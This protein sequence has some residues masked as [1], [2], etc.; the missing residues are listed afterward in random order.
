MMAVFISREK[1]REIERLLESVPDARD[2]VVEAE[3]TLKAISEYAPK[4]DRDW[5]DREKSEL[6]SLVDTWAAVMPSR[7]TGQGAIRNQAAFNSLAAERLIDSGLGFD[8][9]RFLLDRATR[10]FEAMPSV[11]ALGQDV[12]S[13]LETVDRIRNKAGSIVRAYEAKHHLFG[14]VWSGASIDDVLERH[15]GRFSPELDLTFQGFLDAFKRIDGVWPLDYVPENEISGYTAAFFGGLSDAPRQGWPLIPIANLF[16]ADWA[17]GRRSVWESNVD[18]CALGGFILQEEARGPG[19]GKI[20][21]PPLWLASSDKIRRMKPAEVEIEDA[22]LWQAEDAIF[23]SLAR[24]LTGKPSEELRR[25]CDQLACELY[26]SE[27]ARCDHDNKLEE[28]LK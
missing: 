19:E 11:A 26:Q 2:S 16:I 21:P 23:E 5:P 17:V 27:P 10:N 25:H 28:M 4:P 8:A 24:P 12:E 9:I 20:F 3:G 14:K 7:K 1:R 13:F 15:I 22:I 18:T 6:V